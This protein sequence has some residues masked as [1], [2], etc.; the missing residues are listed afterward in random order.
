MNQLRRA[1]LKGTSAAGTLAVAAAAG[2][3]R[4]SAVLAAEWNKAAFEA[5]KVVDVL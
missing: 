2:L 4:P 1:I 5:K 3:I